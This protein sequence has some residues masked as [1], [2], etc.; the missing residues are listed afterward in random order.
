M[1]YNAQQQSLCLLF[2]IVQE[3]GNDLKIIQSITIYL[4][5]PI[6]CRKD[7]YLE[8]VRR[9]KETIADYQ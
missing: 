2:S 1:T 7:I 9:V 5:H 6:L 4:Y 3:T 8:Q